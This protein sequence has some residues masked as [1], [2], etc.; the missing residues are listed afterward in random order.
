MFGELHLETYR[1]FPDVEVVAVADVREGRLREVAA[2]YQIPHTYVN[3]EELC[4]RKDIEMVSVVTPEPLHLAPVLAA[5]QA[6]KHIL[7][8]KPIATNLADAERI[9]AAAE[10]A[11]VH[12]MVGHILRFENNYASLQRE[13]QE[14]H[15][16]KI[17]SL[18]ARRNRPR[19]LYA[20][21]SRAHAILENS[22]HDIDL[23]LWYT[24]DRVVNVR[25]FTRN[26]QGGENPDINWSFL[27][28]AG[29][30]VA[31]IETHWLIPDQ[32][33]IMTNDA[34]QLIGSKAVADIHLVPSA[35]NLWK[36]RGAESVNTTYDARFGGGLHG[37]IR[38]EVGYF[39]DCVR[40][41]EPPKVITPREACEALKVTLALIQSANEQRDVRLPER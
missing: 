2:K 4:A 15:L 35:L 9:I 3:A 11:H 6:G 40:R 21:Y 33:G 13:I 31:C 12:L 32:A 28:F 10:Q 39:V 1:A 38:E 25:A 5:A 18:H 36:E 19:K 29:G 30:A 20:I 7:L 41:G 16:G 34:M 17:V 27:E 22:I 37:A 8:E 23:C 14:G 24:Q 26:I